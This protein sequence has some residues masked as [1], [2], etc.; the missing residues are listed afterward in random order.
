MFMISPDCIQLFTVALLTSLTNLHMRRL[1]LKKLAKH[2][3]QN[4]WSASFQSKN[5]IDRTTI[6]V[7]VLDGY[8]V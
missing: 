6:S 3:N 1:H 7:D 8:K 2:V 5:V 4:L